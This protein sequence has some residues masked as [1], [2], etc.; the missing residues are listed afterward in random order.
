MH[1][2]A[3]VRELS[4]E[5]LDDLI[6]LCRTYTHCSTHGSANTVARQ[7]NMVLGYDT[8]WEG[9]SDILNAIDDLRSAPEP[10]PPPSYPSIHDIVVG[11]VFNVNSLP[12]I[13][14]GVQSL[15]SFVFVTPLG[16]PSENHKMA[17]LATIIGLRPVEVT[18][19]QP[20]PLTIEW[21]DRLDLEKIS[22]SRYHTLAA[23]PLRIYRAYQKDEEGWLLTPEH[24][25]PVPI[26]FSVH[27][28][29]RRVW[30]MSRQWVGVRDSIEQQPTMI[31]EQSGE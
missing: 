2:Q 11:M 17:D 5:E 6:G 19:L 27:A 23:S 30:G 15:G 28:L 22:D 10:P 26:I 18:D 24:E 29:Q 7:I 9:V 21:L 20:V 14:H 12:Y 13:V 16:I 4:D 3:R 25:G 31:N 1:L 8:A